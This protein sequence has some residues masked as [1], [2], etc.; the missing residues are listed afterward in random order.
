MAGLAAAGGPN[1]AFRHLK[2]TSRVSWKHASLHAVLTL[3]VAAQDERKHA[4]NAGCLLTLRRSFSH[5]GT[6]SPVG[7]L[8]FQFPEQRDVRTEIRFDDPDPSP[9]VD[10]DVEPHGADRIAGLQVP[11]SGKGDSPDI[12]GDLSGAS[13]FD[14]GSLDRRGKRQH[15]A[16]AAPD[17]GDDVT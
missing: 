6:D 14:I 16:P 11:C 15:P 12:A 10:S 17:V 3:A 13:P 8:I 7:G 2:M 1:V 9:A 5:K 4:W